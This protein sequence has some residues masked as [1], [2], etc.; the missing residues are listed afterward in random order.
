V[1]NYYIKFLSLLYNAVAFWQLLLAVHTN[2]PLSLLKNK[3]ETLK[4]VAAS[5]K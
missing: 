1:R 5:S 4:D 2:R 3:N